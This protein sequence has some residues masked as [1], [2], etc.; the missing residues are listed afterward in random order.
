[1][2]SHN[3]CRI[4]II[5]IFILIY[6]LPNVDVYNGIESYM[7]YLAGATCGDRHLSVAL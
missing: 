1:M 6:F 7:Y 4:I 2:Y 3:T 5:Y